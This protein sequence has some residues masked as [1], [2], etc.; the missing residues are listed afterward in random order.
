MGA[1]R[2]T[3]VRFIWPSTDLDELLGSIRQALGGEVGDWKD[4]DGELTGGTGFKTAEG[5][6]LASYWKAGFFS[7]LEPIGLSIERHELDD[8]SEGL[9]VYA[10]NPP[11]GNPMG[12][13]RQGLIKIASMPGAQ[14]L[15]FEKVGLG[16]LQ[17][18]FVNPQ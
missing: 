3:A 18:D 15:P 7:S 8:G 9:H 4:D 6:N 13:G 17:V 12:K 10:V 16:R 5:L 1:L 14:W 11:A 2:T